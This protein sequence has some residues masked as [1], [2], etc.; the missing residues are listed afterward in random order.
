MKDGHS[1]LNDIFDSSR[2]G[3]TIRGG[4]DENDHNSYKMQIQ[5]NDMRRVILENQLEVRS[6][7]VYVCETN[8]S[9]T[10]FIY[11]LANK[12]IRLIS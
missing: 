2:H 3:S 4:S 1:K 10:L 8:S 5:A 11:W 6:G 9:V 7:G 12:L